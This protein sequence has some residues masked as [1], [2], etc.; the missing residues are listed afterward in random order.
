VASFCVP[1]ELRWWPDSAEDE[2]DLHLRSRITFSCV[3]R[4]LRWWPDSA[5]DEVDLHLRRERDLLFAC[6]NSLKGVLSKV[7]IS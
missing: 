5:E 3:S 2:V 1:R 6:R 4:E 7:S